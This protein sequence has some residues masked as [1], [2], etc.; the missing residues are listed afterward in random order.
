MKPIIGTGDPRP[1][2]P[3]DYWRASLHLQLMAMPDE[4]LKEVCE[5]LLE[6]YL[7]HKAHIEEPAQC[8]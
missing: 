1:P 5:T 8:A 4:A 2:T 3:A 6:I 7:H